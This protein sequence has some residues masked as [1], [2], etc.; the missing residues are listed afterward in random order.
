[1]NN[2]EYLN[3]V[4]DNV[5]TLQS[6]PRLSALFGWTPDHRRSTRSRV[7]FLHTELREKWGWNKTEKRQKQQQQQQLQ[8]ARL[9]HLNAEGDGVMD[10][11]RDLA[12]E[13]ESVVRPTPGRGTREDK[14]QT[15]TH[16]PL[17]LGF[18]V[19]KK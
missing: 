8:Q 9:S 4:S 13:S 11:M 5:P 3:K 16:L 2:V 17:E 18:G 7:D 12:L 1:M 14:R 15:R 6:P 19:E 10:G